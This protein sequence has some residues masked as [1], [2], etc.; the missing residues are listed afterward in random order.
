MPTA[1]VVRVAQ[2]GRGG[3][4]STRGGLDIEG[5]REVLPARYLGRAI[6][7]VLLAED[8]SGPIVG[9]SDSCWW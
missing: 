1:G 2:S 8:A 7:A 9:L 3:V 4:I 6:V 5:H